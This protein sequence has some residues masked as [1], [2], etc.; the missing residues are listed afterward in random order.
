MGYKNNMDWICTG[1]RR[2]F[3]VANWFLEHFATEES[4]SEYSRIALS[5]VAKMDISFLLNDAAEERH[6]SPNNSPSKQISR[7]ELAPSISRAPSPDCV[8]PA[9]LTEK[10]ASE[11]GSNYPASPNSAMRNHTLRTLL[12]QDPESTFL[13]QS[14]AQTTSTPPTPTSTASN[15]VHVAHP[16]RF[17][18][19]SH[20]LAAYFKTTQKKSRS[21]ASEG[22]ELTLKRRLQQNIG[23]TPDSSPKKLIRTADTEHD[24]GPS[25]LSSANGQVR[26]DA[27]WLLGRKPSAGTRTLKQLLGIND[28]QLEGDSP[29]PQSTAST[30]SPPSIPKS[31]PSPSP[32]MLT[33]GSSHM[34][35]RSSH[36]PSVGSLLNNNNNGSTS[37][38]SNP[39][40]ASNS[41]IHHPPSPSSQSRD[42]QLLN[43]VQKF[44][45]K[46]DLIVQYFPGSSPMELQKR[47]QSLVGKSV[48]PKPSTL[49]QGPSFDS[50]HSSA[51]LSK[52]LPAQLSAHQA[53]QP[54][55]SLPSH[56]LSS[57]QLGSQLNQRSHLQHLPS[58]QPSH[59]HSQSLYPQ[60]LSTLPSQHLSQSMLPQQH[61][62]SQ[63]FL[64]SQQHAPSQHILTQ[65]HQPALATPASNHFLPRSFP[66]HSLGSYTLN[67]SLSP[68]LATRSTGIIK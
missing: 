59:S 2:T 49:A 36:L 42:D 10:R 16:A 12:G 40:G 66:S 19:L 4:L 14:A 51:H 37:N 35:E 61:M 45:E 6:F 11:N 33:R 39:H 1:T 30:P 55:Q 65:N 41:N 13:F 56:L 44:G 38:N 58:Q 60:H 29:S 68:N 62:L 52:Y 48:P 43:V 57:S 7:V 20:S 28:N 54:A 34:A 24:L 9:K 32:S 50:S 22:N 8:I 47:W 63:S 15:D 31:N 67:H 25:S 53:H 27:K 3:C 46:W 26:D 21:S 23:S 5:K 64:S 17:S 18:S